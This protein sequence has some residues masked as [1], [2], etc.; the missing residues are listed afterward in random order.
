MVVVAAVA[1]AAREFLH[2]VEVCA[3][4]MTLLLQSPPIG[5]R[6]RECASIICATP[7]SSLHQDSISFRTSQMKHPASNYSLL[8][9]KPDPFLF[10]RLVSLFTNIIHHREVEIILFLCAQQ[11][12]VG[13]VFLFEFENWKFDFE[14]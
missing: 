7:F 6:L 2:P 10:T 12:T 11:L 9:Q 14:K 5:E 1:A 3:A 8:H 4:A 13:F